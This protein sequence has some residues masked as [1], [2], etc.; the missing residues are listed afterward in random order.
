MLWDLRAGNAT[1]SIR[2]RRIGV[3]WLASPEVV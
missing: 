2:E 3:N 1:G